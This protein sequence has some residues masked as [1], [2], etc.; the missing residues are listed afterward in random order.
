[1]TKVKMSAPDSRLN[2]RT[3]RLFLNHLAETANVAASARTAGIASSS[4]YAERRRSAGFRDDWARALG[5][6]Y[7][8]LET[9]LLAEALLA[10]NGKTADTTLK[11]RAQK[12]RLAIA[13]LSAHRA[14]V[15]GAPASSMPTPAPKDLPT[16]KAQLILKL[17]Q[18]RERAGQ[19]ND[20]A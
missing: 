10:A 16:L 8:R 17:T 1:M 15:K 2:A 20:P 14:A 6:G 9:D 5:E 11:A 3:R 13:L 18:M 19:N 4:V 12:H 7:A